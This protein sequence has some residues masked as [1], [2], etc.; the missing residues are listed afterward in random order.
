MNRKSAQTSHHEDISRKH[1]IRSGSPRTLGLV[2]ATVFGII[3]LYPLLDDGEV[4]AW[5]FWVMVTLMV[6]SLLRPNVL[7]PLNRV[8]FNFGLALHGIVSPIVLGFLFYL[9]IT[10]IGILMRMTGKDPLGL[11]M[12][13]SDR[14]YWIDRSPPGPAPDSM[15]HQF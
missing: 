9:V 8:W 11:A 15:R 12:R 6:I 13:D 3:S 1:D 10:P 5:S 4:R 7:E 2:F 14:S